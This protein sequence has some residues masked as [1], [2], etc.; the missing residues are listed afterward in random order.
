[1]LG[2]VFLFLIFWLERGVRKYSDA[3]SQSAEGRR[4][5]MHDDRDLGHCAAYARGDSAISYFD[6]LVAREVLH[7]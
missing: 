6:P 4:S 7:S 2:I 1:M 3:S 5:V